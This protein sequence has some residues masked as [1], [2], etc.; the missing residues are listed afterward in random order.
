MKLLRYLLGPELLLPALTVVGAIA[1]SVRAEPSQ[2]V[3]PSAPDAAVFGRIVRLDPRFDTLLGARPRLQRVTGGHAWLEGP[4]WNARDGYLLYTDIPH[5]AVFKFSP[6]HGT[7]LFL[8]PSGY[9]GAGP[10]AG[11][12]PG[13]NGLTFDAHGRLVLAEHGDRRV[14]RLEAN[15][16]RTVLAD[17]YQGKRLN[18]PNDVV[19]RSNGDLYFTDPPFGLPETFA[20]PARELDFC[21]VYRLTRDGKLSLLAR[22]IGAPNGIAF[23][24]DER[25]LYVTDVNPARPAWLAYD[26][27]ADGSLANGRVFRAADFWMRTRPG[28]PDGLK[29]DKAGNIFAAGP[30]GVYVFAPD[31]THLGTIETGVATSNVAWG[32]DGSVLYIT[33]STAVYRIKLGTLGAGFRAVSSRDHFRTPKRIRDGVLP[34][35]A[36][37]GPLLAADEFLYISPRSKS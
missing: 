11:K 22:D 30:G 7:R 32:E 5:N 27:H 6:G 29:T 8:K 34:V 2:A 15:G 37:R 19:F 16:N 26:V 3:M 25:T 18:S 23:S 24:P 1:L 14:T 4:V 31:G 9:S 35:Q 28:G 12:E 13:A 21:G 10:F 33:A 20:D 17:R 36:R